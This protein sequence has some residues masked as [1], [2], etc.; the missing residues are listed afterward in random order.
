MYTMGPINYGHPYYSSRF[1]EGLQ[2]C[3]CVRKFNTVV[4]VA[5]VVVGMYYCMYGLY[6]V[7]NGI[8]VPGEPPAAPADHI[9]APTNEAGSQQK[10][11]Y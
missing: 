11:A 1:C 4:C 2:I 8:R 5:G 7:P 6:M 10:W 9:S 3:A